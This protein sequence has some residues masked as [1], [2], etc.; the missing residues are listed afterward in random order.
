MV[1]LT[2]GAGPDTLTGTASSDQL[3]GA[4]GDDSLI[5]AGGDDTLL[6]GVGND[7]L[8][9]GDGL[10]QLFGQDGDD[11][12]L[13]GAGYDMLEGGQ[14]SD[15]MD[16]GAW[17]DRFVIRDGETG[18][19]TVVGGSEVDT[20]EVSRTDGWQYTYSSGQGAGTGAAPGNAA[21][22]TFSGVEQVIAGSGNDT[23]TGTAAG[24]AINFSGNGGDDSILGSAFNDT[25][26]GGTGNDTINGAAGNDTLEGG[27]GNDTIDGGAGDDAIYIRDTDTSG[28][29]SV[30]G[31][32]GNDGLV[33]NRTDNWTVTYGPG[34]G[35]GTATSAN[36]QTVVNF[37]QLEQITGG[38]GHDLIDATNAGS[39]VGGWGNDGNDT[40]LGGAFNDTM[41]SGAG[42]DSLIGAGG[43]DAL[44]GADGGDFIDGGI[45]ADNLH[46]E[47]GND[48]INGGDGADLIIGQGAGIGLG[49][50]QTDNDL[51]SG[52]EGNDAIYGDAYNSAATVAGNDTIDAGGGN[53]TIWAGGLND[54]ALGGAG[55]DVLWGEGG[56]DTLDGATG[57]DTLWGGV[58]TDRLSG[59]D[60]NDRLDGLSD[61]DTLTG[62]AG[63]DTFIA[64]TGDLITDFNA[65]NT[66]SITDGNRANNDLVDLSTY[67]SANNLALWNAAHP[68]QQYATPL[69]WLRADQ[70]SG[71]L[72]MLDGSN[73]LPNL[74]LTIQNGGVAVAGAQLTIENTNV[75]CFASGTLIATDQGERAV[76]DLAVGD[77]VQTRDNGLQAVRWIG[78]RALSED[79]LAA[80]PR[81]R[82]IRIRTGA[83]GQGLPAVDLLVSP[84][85]R[86]LVRSKIARRMFGASEVLIAAKQLCQL[87]GIDIAEDMAGVVYH[88]I[89]FDRHEVVIS[90]GAETESL[91]AGP[92]ALK[93]LGPAAQA[94]LSALFPELADPDFVPVAA[95]V[96]SSGRM[97]RKLVVRHAQNR[98]TLLG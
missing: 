69:G 98:I 53:D 72:D 58:G 14:G 18:A 55:N 10:D 90:N 82:P 61:A 86:V 87:E 5:G 79:D 56:N 92:E 54:S 31:G 41:F 26:N 94:E 27:L 78:A 1:T 40:F 66:G 42:S 95:R 91:F 37:S 49:N 4:G 46:G 67:Y 51:I 57:N 25:L 62:G 32:V 8:D 43:N 65:G 47:W 76:E 89:M 96:I 77:L 34:Q 83:L 12:L 84:Q 29:D 19:D 73:G 93:S 45:G 21:S 71:R 11:T 70:A 9:G 88:H 52:G 3:T 13:G 24:S 97:G 15:S 33:L 85:H 75:P 23:V 35:V 80:E 22:V 63:N 20:L 74:I 59:G 68:D 36:G 30:I 44:R 60:D 17:D 81:L 50:G 2:G 16:G 39:A 28:T 38:A 7:T 64:G 6:G 48:T